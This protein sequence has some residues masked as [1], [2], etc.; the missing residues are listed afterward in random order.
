MAKP[1][2]VKE[3]QVDFI[4]IVTVL[5]MLALG[6]V[7]VL[8]ASSPSSLA[9]SGDAYSYVKTQG[10]SAIVGLIFMMFISKIDYR[11]YKNLD[12]I[13]YIATL[14]ILSAVLIPSLRYE[15]HGAARWINLKFTTFQPSEVAK[16]A[17]VVFYA[18]YL[19]NNREKLGKLW[20]GFIKPIIYLL[21]V[22]AILIFIQD[23]LSASV[24]I[25][26]I[27][28]VMMIVA[29]SKLRYFLTFG[30]IGA[31]RRSRSFIH[32]CEIFKKRCI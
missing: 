14:I 32:N 20:D 10:I 22:L 13:A 21:P 30:T 19:S 1:K 25:V 24:L 5:I 12:K 31:V 23:H 28:S 9:E 4:L 15:S 8:S 11:K 16:V 29:G 26:L 7:M 17:L 2:K 3:K 18:S 6:I 27:V